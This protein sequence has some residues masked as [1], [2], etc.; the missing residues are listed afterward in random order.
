MIIQMQKI[1]G[2]SFHPANDMEYEKTTKFKTG[3]I[4]PIEMKLIRN[5]AFH[6]KVFAFFKF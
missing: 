2:G 5:P 1:A 4:Y 6:R 3:E